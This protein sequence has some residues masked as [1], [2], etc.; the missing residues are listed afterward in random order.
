[1][2]GPKINVMDPLSTE[3]VSERNINYNSL[4]VNI[5]FI[6]NLYCN[7]FISE[8]FTLCFTLKT[9]NFMK[10]LGPSSRIPNLLTWFIIGQR[11]KK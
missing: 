11:Q 7:C 3:Y 2:P 5:I 8:L 4:N 10:T 1:M 6:Q 9:I